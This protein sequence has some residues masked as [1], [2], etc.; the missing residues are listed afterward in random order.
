[1]RK[2]QKLLIVEYGAHFKIMEQ[3]YWS[4]KDEFA[5]TFLLPK[6]KN[7]ELASLFPSRDATDIQVFSVS[8]YLISLK[9]ILIGRNSRWINV[10]TGPEG[11]HVTDSLNIFFFYL[12]C[13]LY[14]KK[15][16]LTVKNIMVYF[17]E[18]WSIFNVLRWLSLNLLERFTFETKTMEKYFHTRSTNPRIKT[19]VSYDRYPD[20]R[21]HIQKNKCASV[22]EEVFDGKKMIIGLLG[23]VDPKRRNYSVVAESL[24]HLSTK[25]LSKIL[26]VTLGTCSESD[27]VIHLGQINKLCPVYVHEQFISEDDFASLGSRCDVLIAPVNQS[28]GYGYA[29]GTGSIG[30]SLY[31]KKKL[32]CP[33]FM[34]PESEFSKNTLMYESPEDISAH[35]LNLMQ[36]EVAETDN[37]YF[38]SFYS[39][40]VWSMVIQD[41]QLDN[42]NS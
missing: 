32:I 28:P 10:S 27:F 31:L 6:N 12:F 4:L 30:D 19:A 38:E 24:R 8:P 2:K 26:F 23:S 42:Q 40:T 5:L 22:P 36:N 33:T 18:G 39:G 21:Q 25:D 34:D 13:L 16:I 29:K 20:L 15:I 9:L 7:P 14:R 17:F 41:L 1:M 37:A 35:L 3:L 11:S